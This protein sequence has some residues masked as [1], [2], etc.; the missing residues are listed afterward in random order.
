MTD[1]PG[2]GG[3]PAGLIAERHESTKSPSRALRV[4]RPVVGSSKERLGTP[5][6][7]HIPFP[8]EEFDRL[9]HSLDGLAAP[10]CKAQ[11]LGPVEQHLRP[12]VEGVRLL[13]QTVS[14]EA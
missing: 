12:D 6:S 5:C 3:R 7:D 1:M 14:L 8:L 2:N 10:G 13:C 9:G 11:Y 4:S